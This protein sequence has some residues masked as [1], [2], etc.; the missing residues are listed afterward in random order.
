MGG[1]VEVRRDVILIDWE[2]LAWIRAQGCLI[3]GKRSDVDHVKAR[4][5]EESKRNDYLALPLCREHHVERG[6]IGNQ[7][8]EEK[9]QINL[10]EELL[11][12]FIEWQKGRKDEG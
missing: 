12:N 7:K 11:W 9:Y 3:D 5:W 8:F 2:Y 1:S 10:Y 6:Q 4:G